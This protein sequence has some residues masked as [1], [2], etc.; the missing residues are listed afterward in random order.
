MKINLLLLAFL[1]IGCHR[2]KTYTGEYRAKIDNE[3]D[4]FYSCGTIKIEPLGNNTETV[5]LSDSREIYETEDA[6]RHI[7]YRAMKLGKKVFA[8][9]HRVEL[10]ELPPQDKTS[11][12]CVPR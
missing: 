9:V 8:G 6:N 12:P 10:S 11:N 3:T 5:V 4:P 7:E 2:T 1:L